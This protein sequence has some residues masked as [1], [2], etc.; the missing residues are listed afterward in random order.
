VTI[1]A[2]VVC[3]LCSAAFLARGPGGS[4]GGN[5][6]LLFLGYSALG[7]VVWRELR[8]RRLGR[9]V[10]LGLSGGLLVLAVVVPPTQSGDVWAYAMYGRIVSQHHASPY[11][12]AAADYPRDPAAARV[13]RVWRRTKSVYGPG[14]TWLSAAGMRVVGS[15]RLAARLFFQI[16]AAIA[17]GVVLFLVDRRARDPLALACIGLNP[18]IV[19]GVVNNAHN[20][21]LVGLAV[22]GAVLLVLSGRPVAAGLAGAAGALVKLSALV[23]MAAVGW[24]LWRRRGWRPAAALGAATLLTVALAFSVAGG[25]A[26]LRPLS[27]AG[28]QFTGGSIW[29][30]PQRWVARSKID[31]GLP[32]HV[33]HSRAR[34]EVARWA[35]VAVVALAL[36]LAWRRLRA[37][38]P[39][40]AAG[41]A[42]LG[43]MLGAGYV[44][45]WYAAWSLPALAI[46]P[47]SRL[48]WLVA[49]HAAV[50]QFVILRDPSMLPGH[51]SP[52]DMLP[53]SQR[54]LDDVYRVG[55]PLLQAVLILGLVAGS[56]RPRAARS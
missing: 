22:L 5:Q 23:P 18:V 28:H 35:A 4:L 45:P 13:D 49:A 16:V 7:V 32:E 3:A 24:W 46:E 15:S 47:R 34:A 26:A 20:D 52:L 37:A 38:T 14:F 53:A 36:L 12:H 39:A 29:N 11:T 17:I 21:A 2:A 19:L 41:A 8:E 9:R 30:G 6:V 1:V 44:Y 40:G 42:V 33:A 54:L 43:F 31:A 27:A 55:F 50:L 10:L 56:L 51:L 48:T 25:R